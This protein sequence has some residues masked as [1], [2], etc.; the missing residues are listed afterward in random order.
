MTDF[1]FVVLF[2]TVGL[3]EVECLSISLMY[4][5]VTLVYSSVGGIIYLLRSGP[6]MAEAHAEV[7]AAEPAKEPA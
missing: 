3:A 4:V 2:G 7:L 6:S 5:T 1:G